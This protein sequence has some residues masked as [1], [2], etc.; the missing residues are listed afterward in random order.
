MTGYARNLDDGSVQVVACGTQAQVDTLVAWLKQGGRARARA[1]SA[2]W[3]SRRAWS[4]TPGLA[5]AIEYPPVAALRAERS[6]AFYRFR[7][8]GDLGSLFGRP[9]G[10]RRYR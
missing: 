5:F 4:I 6:D 10:N 7:Q 8:S 1:S 9:F 3:W 2:C